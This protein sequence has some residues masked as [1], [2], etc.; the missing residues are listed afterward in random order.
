MIEMQT[1][2]DEIERLSRFFNRKLTSDQLEI[3]YEK[4]RGFSEETIHE[5][6]ESIIESDNRVFPPLGTILRVAREIR[7]SKHKDNS[8]NIMGCAFCRWGYVW[9]WRNNYLY[10]GDCAVCHQG[11]RHIRQ[12]Y[13]MRI[14]EDIYP[15]YKRIGGLFV[16]SPQDKHLPIEGATP[17]FRQVPLD[18]KIAQTHGG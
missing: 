16:A 5:T 7:H 1:F 3:H 10:G 11:Q 15:A 4:L 18:P 8:N 17:A 6:V 13:L 12:R 9:F 14:G 2:V